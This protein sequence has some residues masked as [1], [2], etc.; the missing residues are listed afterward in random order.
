MQTQKY[1]FNKKKKEYDKVFSITFNQ[2]PIRMNF[3]IIFIVEAVFK[4]LVGLYKQHRMKYMHGFFD[5]DTLCR[6]ILKFSF[7][8]DAIK[9]HIVLVLHENSII[10]YSFI[11]ELCIH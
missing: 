10:N 5:D 7:Y 4:L 1:H 2:L 9:Y 8:Y 3:I 11:F 6:W